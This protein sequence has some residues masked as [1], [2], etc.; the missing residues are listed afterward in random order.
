[1]DG[2]AALAEGYAAAMQLVSASQLPQLLPPSAPA[3]RLACA[4]SSRGGFDGEEAAQET[5]VLLFVG[6]ALR[7]RLLHLGTRR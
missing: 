7:A 1:M 2:D 5:A 3:G 4:E 6:V